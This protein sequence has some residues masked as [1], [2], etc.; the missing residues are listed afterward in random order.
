MFLVS[1]KSCSSPVHM[2]HVPQDNLDFVQNGAL[3]QSA[4]AM[5]YLAGLG[6]CVRVQANGM[7]MRYF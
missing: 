7:H 5:Y 2:A 1:L 4:R 3:S 6:L